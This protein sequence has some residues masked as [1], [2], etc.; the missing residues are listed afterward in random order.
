LKKLSYVKIQKKTL[1]KLLKMKKLIFWL[2][3][4]E[5]LVQLKGFDF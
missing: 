1:F 4:Q 5:V 2:W 3:D